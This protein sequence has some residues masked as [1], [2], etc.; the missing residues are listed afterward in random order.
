MSEKHKE[1]IDY[2]T[3]FILPRK[4]LTWVVSTILILSVGMFIIGY[5]LGQKQATARFLNKV[6]EDSFADKITYSLYAINGQDLPDEDDT[7]EQQE[8]TVQEATTPS[9]RSD[10]KVEEREISSDDDDAITLEKETKPAEEQN[11]VYYAPLVGFGTLRAADHCAQQLKSIGVDAHL[12]E[13]VSVTPRGRKITWYQLVTEDYADQKEL[14][15]V[16]AR[17]KQTLN[18]RSIKIIEKRKVA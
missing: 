17:V 12:I 18:I 4:E 15:S 2:T 14:E 16:I 1:H 8:S 5:V 3:H 9:E 11:T 13:R 6:D 10:P 7:D